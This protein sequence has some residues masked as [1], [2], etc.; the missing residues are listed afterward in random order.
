MQKR[1]FVML[2]CLV[3]AAVGVTRA[4]RA[5]RIP[6]RSPFATFPYEIGDW[7]GQAEPP[8]TQRELEVLGLD[9]Y[10]TRTYMTSAKMPVG[11]YIGYWQSQRQGSTI[12]SPQNCLPGAGWEPIS[13]TIMT[14]ADPRHP[15]G[16]PVEGN[17]YV[18]QKGLDR[19]LVL[20][21][22]QSHGRIVASE[23]WSRFYLLTDAVRMDRTDGAI[24]RLTVPIDTRVADGEQ[25]A[26][27]DAV[28][29]GTA[30]LPRLDAFLPN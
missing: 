8:F 6:P 28:A 11:L 21:W 12:H 2:V 27:R 19:V 23:Y 30:L 16:P 25:R 9:D 3:V 7:R 10:L 22:F 1:V 13:Q 29:F 15:N 5:E 24:V 20:Y 18:I 4:N 26:E 17:R 14:F